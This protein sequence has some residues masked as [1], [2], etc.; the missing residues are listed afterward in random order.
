MLQ[1]TQSILDTAPEVFKTKPSDE[2]AARVAAILE[3]ISIEP[4]R[5]LASLLD[6]KWTDELLYFSQE[7]GVGVSLPDLDVHTKVGARCI[8]LIVQGDFMLSSMPDID[9][10]EFIGPIIAQCCVWYYG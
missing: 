4:G 6:D 2:F 5:G 8:H 7:R 1:I 3:S 10:A 9:P